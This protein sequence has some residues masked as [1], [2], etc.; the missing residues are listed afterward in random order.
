MQTL[1]QRSARPAGA[2]ERTLA[3]GPITLARMR[4]NLGV[5]AALSVACALTGV[6]AWVTVTLALACAVM[7]LTVAA[8]GG[9]RLLRSLFF[10]PP[11]TR[12]ARGPSTDLGQGADTPREK[13]S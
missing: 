10:L 4:V 12:H 9:P 2:R 8:L 7:P 13:C 1:P 11:R 5:W 3:A 6:S